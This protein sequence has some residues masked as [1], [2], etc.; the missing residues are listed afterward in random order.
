[1]TELIGEYR[2]LFDSGDGGLYLVRIYAA[3][4][5]RGSW[6]A[7]FVFVPTSGGQLLVTDRETTQRNPA[8]LIS[9][10]N[11]ISRVYLDG[12]YGRARRHERIADVTAEATEYEL[13]WRRTAWLPAPRTVPGPHPSVVGP[14]AVLNGQVGISLLG[15]RGPE[16]QRPYVRLI[17]RP[18]DTAGLEASR[19]AGAASSSD[20]QPQRTGRAA[21]VRFRCP[22][23][24]TFQ[25][26]GRPVRTRLR[27]PYRP[28]AACAL[29]GLPR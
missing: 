7:W 28:N 23:G 13:G 19:A 17:G 8:E 2:K 9:W 11:G 18:R 15:R 6:E 29:I 10:A 1:L 27:C 24:C 5:P 3:R 26:S 21:T 16:T 14:I 12:A 25:H 22:D 20:R 4:Q